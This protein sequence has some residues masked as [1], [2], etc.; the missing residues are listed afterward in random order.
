M[1]TLLKPLADVFN[2]VTWLAAA[3][4]STAPTVW[5]NEVQPAMV[6]IIDDLGY[7]LANGLGIVNLPGPITLAVMPHTPH[8]ALLAQR[9]KLANK[10][11]MLHVPMENHAGLRL[12]PGGLT[13][14]MQE[15]EFKQVLR[16]NLASIPHVQGLNNH[17]GSALTEQAL[18]MQWTMDLAKELNLF[19]VDS[20]T[21]AKSLALQQALRQQ[22]PALERDV[23]L[24]NDTAT[25]ALT[26]QFEQAMRIAHKYGYVVLIGHPY[27]ATIAFLKQK[28]P[29]LDQSGIMLI[30]ASALI[31]QLKP[32][33]DTL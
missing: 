6:I 24:D 32:H 29:Q 14:A 30:S 9:G 4:I 11:V 21:S 7:N 15:T 33:L 27:P 12:G 1:M 22:V 13:L 17:M 26:V 25:K 19:F 5:A 31:N 10:E 3:L 23:F 8:G 20:R 18:P 16:G 2:L 28:L